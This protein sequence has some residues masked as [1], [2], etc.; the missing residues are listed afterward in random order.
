VGGESI[1]GETMEM[2]KETKQAENAQ[3]KKS[4]SGK[5]LARKVFPYHFIKR[6]PSIKSK[7]K[8]P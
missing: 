4:S 7:Y 1:C 8:L 3:S 6:I 5:T 2:R